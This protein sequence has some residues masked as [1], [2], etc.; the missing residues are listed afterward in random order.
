MKNFLL[1]VIALCLVLIV[2]RLYP[3]GDFVRAARAQQPEAGEVRLYGC[4]WLVRGDAYNCGWSPV[5]LNHRGEVITVPGPL[6]FPPLPRNK[7]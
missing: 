3:S 5:R 7:R 4:E 2:L 6:P 1:F